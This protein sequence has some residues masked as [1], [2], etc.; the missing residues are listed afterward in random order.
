MPT[1][2]SAVVVMTACLLLLGCSSEGRPRAEAGP[3]VSPVAQVDLLPA[4][5][6]DANLDEWFGGPDPIYP[7]VMSVLVSQ[8]GDVV[9]ERYLAK[10]GR[11]AHDIA[12]VT[13]SVVS[14]LVGI[15]VDDG[16]L[17][18]DDTLAELLPS[19]AS[20][21]SAEVAE[22]RL[23]Q[24]LTMSA[25]FPRDAGGPAEPF[26]ASED[27][28]DGILQD[29]NRGPVGEFAYSSA[30][31]HLLGAIVAEATGRTLRAYAEERLFGPLGIDTRGM[32]TPLLAMRN[33]AAYDA[34]PLA[35]PVDPSGRNTGWGFLKLR[36]RDLLRIGRLYLAGGE[37][38]G[39]RVVSHEWVDQ[40]TS[41]HLEIPEPG[42]MGYGFQWWVTEAGGAPAAVAMG[43]GGQLIE[44]VPDHDLVVVTTSRI[45]E[46][47]ALDPAQVLEVVNDAMFEQP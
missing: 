47:R 1:P 34:A 35:W 23:E 30:T 18:L 24:L 9:L 29:T 3:P 28:V 16:L 31:S 26:M 33:L 5:E 42:G 6:I 22:V 12:S 27:W 43:Y 17:E 32:T 36:P 46:P 13:K 15:A 41:D 14:T 40:A 44:V 38:E 39:E 21:M 8:G 10:D 7:T 37:W 19:H 11:R 2:R 20:S 25:G 45:T 4:G